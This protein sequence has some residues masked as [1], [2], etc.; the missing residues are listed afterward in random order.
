MAEF[1]PYYK[2]LG[3]LPKDQPANHYRL[4]GIERFEGDADVIEAAA[5][6]RMAH[7]R[8]YQTG[9]NSALSQ[10]ILNELSAA[11]LCLLDADKKADYD[12]KLRA[13]LAAKQPTI[14][15]ATPLEATVSAG[16][17]RDTMA[18][19]ST[20][21][22]TTDSPRGSTSAAEKHRSPRGPIPIMSGIGVVVLAVPVVW[23]ALAN[24]RDKSPQP[25]AS[26]QVERQPRQPQ[27]TAAER[28]AK[29]QRSDGRTA[30]VSR[31]GAISEG[32]PVT[33]ASGDR[34][35]AEEV[36]RRGG[37]VTVLAAG[38]RL[39]IEPTASLPSSDF[40]LVGARLE[41]ADAEKVAD[42]SFLAR[43]K[44]LESLALFDSRITAT[45]LAPFAGH[46]SL[47]KLDL[48][49][50]SQLADSGFQWLKQLPVLEWLKL[51]H[52]GLTDES[53]AVLAELP[54][55]KTLLLSDNAITDVG[56]KRLA[57]VPTLEQLDL[58]NTRVSSKA[59]AEL[60]QALPNCR[61]VADT[62]AQLAAAAPQPSGANDKKSP[63]PPVAEKTPERPARLPLPQGDSL[64]KAKKLVRET[65]QTELSA[66][67]QAEGL[68]TLLAAARETTDDP[69]GR[70]AL[71]WTVIEAATESGDLRLAFKAFDELGRHFE[72]DA[73]AAKAEAL[74]EAAKT[75]RENK[76]RTSLVN[77]SLELMEEGAAAGRFDLAERAAKVGG[78]LATR[79]KN[80]ELRKD[81]AARRKA[82]DKQRKAHEAREEA[83]AAARRTLA[84]KPDDPAANEIL[85]KYL[86]VDRNDWIAGLPH[87]AKARSHKL[88]QAAQLDLA[89]AEEADGQLAI[90][91]GWWELAASA[92]KPEA[93]AYRSRAVYWY[94]LAVARLSGLSHAK[95]EKRIA[96]A[97]ELGTAGQANIGKGHADF[98][99]SPGVVLRLVEIPATADGKVDS[100]WLGET[101]VTEAQWCAV[102]GGEAISPKLPKGEVDMASV[103]SFI[104]NLNARTSRFRFRLPQPK[105]AE[106]AIGDM[107]QYG[108]ETVWYDEN[109]GNNV[110]AVATKKPN[111]LGVYDIIGNVWEWCDGGQIYGAA[112]FDNRAGLGLRLHRPAGG[113]GRRV[114]DVGFRV[115]ADVQ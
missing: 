63:S 77:R 26:R 86:C 49:G 23:F 108:P 31:D 33:P 18:A 50:N 58:N 109:S 19:L 15:R 37:G 83:I 1:D 8:T 101:E 98:L 97:G 89:G 47:K 41:H 69:I 34:L 65:Y 42:L 61:V 17:R 2:W 7:V 75:A 62:A 20:V 10:K 43:A 107:S 95:A 70:A 73:M 92:D 81:V 112:F 115:A 84:D 28:L 29:S 113:P 100:F 78:S 24:L 68:R 22:I 74:E 3:I 9:Q 35:I 64:A 56:L 21:N 102:T 114:R 66:K 99:L 36:L 103:E 5:D 27:E 60:R 76:L 46:P 79:L 94:S 51:D 85:G 4:L 6:Q 44:H 93:A 39:V 14:L 16:P 54:A 104:N 80:S 110:H 87:L 32:K 71:L 82:L 45:S 106:L 105:E 91:D 12:A 52:S 48:A 55:I 57:S 88:Q 38:E 53:A 67:D 111:T 40:E 96:E 59:V 90:G 72:F 30:T 13:E 11:K 25:S